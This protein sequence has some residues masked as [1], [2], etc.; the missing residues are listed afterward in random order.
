MKLNE[1]VLRQIIK[2]IINE[3]FKNQSEDYP[4]NFFKTRI[5]SLNKECRMYEYMLKIYPSIEETIIKC[6]AENNVISNDNDFN[7]YVEY[8]KTRNCFRIDIE[9]YD[10]DLDE[11]AYDERKIKQV[12]EESINVPFIKVDCV[13]IGETQCQVGLWF[14]IED[15]L[16]MNKW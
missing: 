14:E 16:K 1:T 3:S 8:D 12:I 11:F 2:N 15:I 7:S 6:L 10:L 4:M 13:R 9:N 5:D